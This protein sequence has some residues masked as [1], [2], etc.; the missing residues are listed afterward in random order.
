MK[1]TF[2]RM[3]ESHEFERKMLGE[4]KNRTYFP[5]NK[6]AER[7]ERKGK[8]KS[9]GQRKEKKYRKKERSKRK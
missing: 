6:M 7:E 4:K 8:R 3:K 2:K 5:G 1:A 9:F